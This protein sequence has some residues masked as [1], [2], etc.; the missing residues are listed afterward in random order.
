MRCN[1]ARENDQLTQSEVARNGTVDSKVAFSRSEADAV[2]SKRA[3]VSLNRSRSWDAS[4]LYIMLSCLS[5][6]GKR[7]AIVDAEMTAEA[8]RTELTNLALIYVL[9]SR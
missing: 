1:G 5:D 3:H 4:D 6:R 7:H 2:H 8:E 9:L